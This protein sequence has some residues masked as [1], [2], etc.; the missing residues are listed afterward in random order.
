MIDLCFQMKADIANVNELMDMVRNTSLTDQIHLDGQTQ[1]LHLINPA[2]FVKEY[3]M[4][5]MQTLSITMKET[6]ALEKGF[7]K[8][9]VFDIP[10]AEVK[11]NGQWTAF[12]EKNK[13][14]I[15]AQNPF[16]L[17]WRI[18][19]D[20]FRL[21]GYKQGDTVKGQILVVDDE[22]NGLNIAKEITIQL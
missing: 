17:E 19:G 4:P 9:I 10:G 15:L 3:L 16:K 14:L 22:W 13:E 21:Y 7:Y 20:L 1:E 18:N 2:G 8:G 5:A 6:K 11:I 12:D